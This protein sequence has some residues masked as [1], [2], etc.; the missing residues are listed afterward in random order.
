[1]YLGFSAPYG[2][3]PPLGGVALREEG[4]TVSYSLLAQTHLLSSLP[5]AC[6]TGHM[7]PLL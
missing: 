5:H 3:R 4:M 7:S 6:P 2:F 1:M